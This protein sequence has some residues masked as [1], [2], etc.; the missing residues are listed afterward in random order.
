M[1]FRT[2]DGKY[3][4][5]RRILPGPTVNEIIT[6]REFWKKRSMTYLGNKIYFDQEVRTG[7]CYFCK[8]EGRAQKSRTTY[9]NHVKYEHSDPLAWTIE[10]CSSCHYQIDPYNKKLIDRHY[11]RKGR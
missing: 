4:K 3:R 7:V 2:E 1:S 5:P 10:V 8:R 11:G 6:N 9:L